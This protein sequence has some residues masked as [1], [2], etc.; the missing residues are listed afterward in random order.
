MQILNI[1]TLKNI[2]TFQLERTRDGKV[3]AYATENADI[4][5]CL[6]HKTGDQYSF[7]HD[8]VGSL[9]SRKKLKLFGVAVR[10]SL[11]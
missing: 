11:T 10:Y 6:M 7:G 3:A 9:T 5:L 2:D 1:S 8:V 4:S